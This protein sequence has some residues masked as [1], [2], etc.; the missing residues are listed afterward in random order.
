MPATL[1]ALEAEYLNVLK[2]LNP[3]EQHLVVD[4]LKKLK[5][6][7][8]NTV[9]RVEDA[10]AETLPG[11]SFSQE[12]KSE[13]ELKSLFNYFRRRRQLVE[14]ALTTSQVAELLGTSRQT[15]HDR[16]K[17]QTLLGLLDN[18]VLRFPTW[19]FDPEGPDGVVDG[20]PE[21]LKML[22]VSDF[23]KLNWLVRPQPFLDGLTPI[24]ALKQGY[25]E[26]VIQEAAGAGGM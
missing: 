3:D 4:T 11:R 24:Q 22:Q 26:R 18:G 19:Q 6:S 23:A 25:K 14:G 21:I 7:R 10:L 9:S 5:D 8:E 20:L 12:E 16:V 15:P 13:L 17:A 2:D 1:S